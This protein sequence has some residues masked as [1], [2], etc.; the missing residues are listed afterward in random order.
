MNKVKLE[1][2]LETKQST[3]GKIYINDKHFCYSLELPDKNNEPFISRIPEG[4]YQCLPYSSK[5]YPDVVELQNVKNRSKIL[6]HAGNYPNDTQGCILLGY[7]SYKQDYVG[8]SKKAL[9]EFLKKTS[10]TFEIEIINPFK[11]NKK[12][13]TATMLTPIVGK[14]A[15]NLTSKAKDIVI[16]KIAEKTGVKIETKADI[17]EALNKLPPEAIKEIKVAAVNADQAKFIAEL[18]HGEDLSK[19]WK[20]EV[21]TYSFLGFVSYLFLLGTF[22]SET[23]ISLVKSVAPLFETYFGLTFFLVM[24][25]SVGLKSVCMKIAD[26]FVKKYS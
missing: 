10:L 3:I 12:M 11:E 7:T 13:I 24:I 2:F 26:G 17:N 18:E 6:I 5:K 20:D 14:I 1:R 23:L 9:K 8:T 25:A 21:V 22:S 15:K 4:K 19:T 16:K